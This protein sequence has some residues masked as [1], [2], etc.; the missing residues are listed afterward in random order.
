MK[1]TALLVTLVALP[2][3]AEFT[4]TEETETMTVYREGDQVIVL[5]DDARSGQVIKFMR[6]RAPEQPVG[7][8]V[9]DDAAK[10]AG[11]K[12][13]WSRFRVLDGEVVCEKVTARPAPELRPYILGVLAALPCRTG[14]L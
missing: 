14:L 9:R 7:T 2:A 12:N 8:V 3:A 5:L 1:L 13:Y 6:D 4:I 10:E 11:V